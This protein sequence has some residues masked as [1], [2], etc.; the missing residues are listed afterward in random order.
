MKFC[1]VD[2]FTSRLF[3]GNPAAVCVVDDFPSDQLMQNIATEVN[4]SETAFVCAK[5]DNHFFIRWFT[6]KVEVSLCGHGTLAAAHVLWNALKIVEPEKVIYFESAAGVIPAENTEEG[7]RLNMP[8]FDALPCPMPPD[9]VEALGISPIFIGKDHENYLIEVHSPEE[10]YNLNPDM[11]LL[12]TIESQGFIVTAECPEGSQYDFV[13]RYFAPREG[14]NEDPVT[15]SAHC[16]LAPFW[17]PRLGKNK[18]TAYQASKRGGV[19]KLEYKPDRVYMT[20]MAVTAF[21]GRF[22]GVQNEIQFK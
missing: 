20:G 14:L 3:S 15:G 18:F 11:A 22:V 6:P 8:A 7:I 5:S 9:L 17:S 10:V 1:T 13:S 21:S 2:A 12:S 4:L 16:T 19:L